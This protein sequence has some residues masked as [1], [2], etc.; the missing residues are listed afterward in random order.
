[1]SRPECIQ[2]EDVSQR[3]FGPVDQLPGV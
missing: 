1:L 3:V 2:A